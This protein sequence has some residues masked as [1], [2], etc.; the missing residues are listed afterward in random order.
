MNIDVSSNI[1]Q[2]TKNL[3]KIQKDQLPFATSMALNNVA[4]EVAYAVTKQMEYELDRPTPFTLKAFMTSS[5]KFNGKRATKRSLYAVVE[6]K[7]IQAEYLKYQVYGGTRMPKK[8]TVAVP[9]RNAR[10]NRYGNIANRKRGLIRNSKQFVGEIKGI[11]G[12]WE[13]TGGKRS[14]GVKLIHAFEPTVQYRKRF[15][16]F[17]AAEKVVQRKFGTILAHAIRYATATAR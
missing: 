2:V 3:T 4:N 17:R 11:E 10:L 13:R 12:I 1:A 9:T 14:P 16:P 5:G 15:N 6:S 8:R 7:P